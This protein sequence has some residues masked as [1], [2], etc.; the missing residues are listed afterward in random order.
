V[1]LNNIFAVISNFRTVFYRLQD[2]FDDYYEKLRFY[3]DRQ[4]MAQRGVVIGSL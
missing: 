1:S 2:N 4:T 3:E